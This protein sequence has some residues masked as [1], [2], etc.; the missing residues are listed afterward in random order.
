MG[1]T[2]RT[3]LTTKNNVYI[4]PRSHGHITFSFYKT[5]EETKLINADNYSIPLETNTTVVWIMTESGSNLIINGTPCVTLPRA[6]YELWSLSVI[7]HLLLF[8]ADY[9]VV[10]ILLGLE[11]CNLYSILAAWVL[12]CRSIALKVRGLKTQA[13]KASGCLNAA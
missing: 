10:S 5:N 7:F 6:V 11:A 2:A 3:R 1:E 8:C 13:R 9:C 12:N 4:T